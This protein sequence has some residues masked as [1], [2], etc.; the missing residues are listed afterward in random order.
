MIPTR[1]Y[2]SKL[3]LLFSEKV[4]NKIELIKCTKNNTKGPKIRYIANFLGD[5][6]KM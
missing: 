6:L 5:I 2:D 3:G 1:L 4:L